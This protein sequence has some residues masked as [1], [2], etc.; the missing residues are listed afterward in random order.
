MRDVYAK[1]S[2]KI[3]GAL[4]TES[5]NN[6]LNVKV[7]TTSKDKTYE[8]VYKL[9]LPDNAFQSL[10]KVDNLTGKQISVR[11]SVS[12]KKF[13]D[14][15]YKSVVYVS[16][17]DFLGT[18]DFAEDYADATVGGKIKFFDSREVGIT[19][20]TRFSIEI[21]KTIKD[22]TITNY[23]GG[24]IWDASHFANQELVGTVYGALKPN[25]YVDKE[26]KQVDK[27]EITAYD[28]SFGGA[29]DAKVAKPTPKVKK[30]AEEIPE[31]DLP[32]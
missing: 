23:F 30:T 9:F 25:S 11:G 27:I 13:A 16:K 7:T 10:S 20:V 21:V 5:G 2:G 3:V 31:E 8:D 18:P 1:V 22:K 29:S 6:Y 4:Y 12:D 32:F 14:D 28:T 15:T 17:V 19:N 26:G 24:N